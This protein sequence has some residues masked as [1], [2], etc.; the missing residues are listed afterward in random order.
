[1]WESGLCP[2]PLHLR[3]S[4]LT[5]DEYGHEIPSRHGDRGSQNQHPE[6][7]RRGD[8]RAEVMSNRDISAGWSVEGDKIF[9][10]V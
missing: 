9:A 6:L 8:Q 4:R 2:V 5:N 7:C 3:G 1:M 10:W